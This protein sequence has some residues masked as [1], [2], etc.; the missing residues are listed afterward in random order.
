[1]KRTTTFVTVGFALAAVLS[2]PS[3]MAQ[4]ARSFVSPTGSDSN[5]CTLAAPCRT[6]QAAYNVTNAYGEIAIL[7]TAG[8]GPLTIT[9]SITITNPGGVEAGITATSGQN[10]IS[11]NNT[12]AAT[13]TLRGMTLEG[14][15][16][17]SAGIYLT[18]TANTNL[19]I[20]DCVVKDFTRSGISIV[21]SAGTTTAVIS[22]TYSLNNG[23][24]GIHIIPSGS[25]TVQFSIAQTTASSNGSNGIH[26]DASASGS[27]TGIRGMITGAHTDF[28]N[29]GITGIGNLYI[30]VK[31]SFVFNNSNNG[32]LA[33]DTGLG[34]APGVGVGF[35]L[36]NVYFANN[37]SD[38]N[39]SGSSSVF[40]FGNNYYFTIAG[41]VTSAS[42][43]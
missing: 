19:N 17:G 7:G 24:D 6:F 41:S 35:S 18:S 14:G 23:T 43:N 13:I 12:S 1:M 25:G 16:A 31:D 33:Q 2:A 22:N 9:Q 36:D 15:G 42:L 26:L 27:I 10:A 37:N 21:P 40:S 8:Y 20:I 11:I 34:V 28:N 30:I 39:A 29:N 4:N 3:A 32:L 5:N 38:I